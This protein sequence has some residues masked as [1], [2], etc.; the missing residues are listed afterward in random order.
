[1]MMSLYSSANQK[2]LTYDIIKGMSHLFTFD[3]LENPFVFF[4]IFTY[5]MTKILI[6]S[7]HNKPLALQAIQFQNTTF[8]HKTQDIDCLL[9]EKIFNVTSIS[10]YQFVFLNT[11]QLAAGATSLSS[12]GVTT[13]VHGCSVHALGPRVN[14]THCRRGGNW[15]HLWQS[16][17]SGT[18]YTP[19]CTLMKGHKQAAFHVRFIEKPVLEHRG[20]SQQYNGMQYTSPNSGL[21]IHKTLSPSINQQLQH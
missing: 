17:Q 12:Q 19:D 4:I 15:W 2:F 9:S 14:L 16:R 20:V 6:I 18:E 5:L 7:I 3:Q 8:L 1:M 10:L 13:V 11:L 21:W